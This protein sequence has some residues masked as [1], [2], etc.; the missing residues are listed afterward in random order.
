LDATR[1]RIEI[2]S[3]VLAAL[4]ILATLK[5]GLLSALLAGLAVWEVGNLFVPLLGRAGISHHWGRTVAAGLIAV[6]I[7]ALIT[8]AVLLVIPLISSH[9][10]SFGALFTKMADI[11]STLRAH[12]PAW[13]LAYIPGSGEEL[14]AKGAELLREHAAYLQ[15]IGH[16]VGK[17]LAHAVIGMIIGG[18][19]LASGVN[20][21][22]P[23][24]PLAVAM[25]TRIRAF[26][27]S[28]KRVVFAQ[29][30]ISALNTVLTAIYLAGI[31]PL[32]GIHL[33]L[34]KTMIALTFLVGLI[35]VAGNLIS[36]T[37]IVTVSLSVSPFAAVLSLGFLVAIHK[38]EYFIN[39]K[40][41]GTQ[42]SAKAWEL[43][44]A[45]IVMEAAFGIPGVVAAP[46]FYAYLKDELKSQGL[47]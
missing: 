4:A 9:S 5:L 21:E 38:L 44:V 7:S 29:V 41:I 36:N 30:R 14:Q 10:E 34:V 8:G 40:I 1:H 31:L 20:P 45:M 22:A 17:F 42:I 11:V 47:I 28:F 6:I 33:P 15:V 13:A 26:A 25:L 16:D 43:L 23:S 18:L 19:V 3:Y 32:L 12:V 27:L 24:G 46:I 39:A 2:S 35:P 37:V